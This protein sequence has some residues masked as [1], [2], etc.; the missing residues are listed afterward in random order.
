MFCVQFV[1]S[2]TK[3]EYFNIAA[4]VAVLECRKLSEIVQ[5][6]L[7]KSTHMSYTWKKPSAVRAHALDV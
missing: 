3:I 2:N 7:L 4:V 6:A 1:V 5:K